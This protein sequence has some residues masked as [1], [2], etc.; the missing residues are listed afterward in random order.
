ANQQIAELRRKNRLDQREAASRQAAVQGFQ[1]AQRIPW[2][3][4]RDGDVRNRRL[5][6]NAESW[7][8]DN[9]D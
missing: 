5:N 7:A 8:N 4:Q 3:V 6:R 1:R 2:G 9:D